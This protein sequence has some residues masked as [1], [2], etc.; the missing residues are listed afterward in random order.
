ML[1]FKYEESLFKLSKNKKRIIFS[2]HALERMGQRGITRDQV[3]AAIHDPAVIMPGKNP[4]TH[5]LFKDFIDGRTLKIFFVKKR[6][7]I[8]VISAMWRQGDGK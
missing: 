7:G 3:R 2:D 5:T 6:N 1:Y 4:G 8:I